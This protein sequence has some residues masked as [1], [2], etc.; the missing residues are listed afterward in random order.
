MVQVY[1][2][3]ARCVAARKSR[4]RRP[5]D[6]AGMRVD[7]AHSRSSRSW[8]KRRNFETFDR[9][10][11]YVRRIPRRACLLSHNAYHY[12]NRRF[13]AAYTCT[14]VEINRVVALTWGQEE[15]RI[16]YT[17]RPESINFPSIPRNSIARFRPRLEFEFNTHNLEARFARKKIYF[18]DI[19]IYI[20]IQCIKQVASSCTKVDKYVS[21]RV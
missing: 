18:Y 2:Y 4:G 8:K 6:E 15:G 13:P 21:L 20:H 1:L 10:L 16:Q 3:A 12:A 14:L 5:V 9:A 19:Y 17:S 7:G 11:R